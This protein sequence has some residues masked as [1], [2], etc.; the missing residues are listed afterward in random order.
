MSRI[1]KVLIVEDSKSDAKLIARELRRTGFSPRWERVET[2]PALREALLR[3]R[4]QLVISESTLPK[5]SLLEALAITKEIRSTTPFIVVS[6][7]INEET[8]GAAIR[9]G[10]AGYVTK[11]KLPGLGPALARELL[12]G[13]LRETRRDEPVPEPAVREAP[14]LQLVRDP[15]VELSPTVLDRM[16]LPSAIRWLVDR[17]SAWSTVAARVQLAPVGRLPAAV[18]AA[19]FRIAQEALANAERH[20]SARTLRVRLTARLGTIEIVVSDDG[21]G[22]DVAAAREKAAAGGSLGLLVMQEMVSLAGGELDIVSAP[23]RGTTVRARFPAPEVA[24]P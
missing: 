24:A 13:P 4:W 14:R 22:F 7:T 18:E 12:E 15:S 2:A 16:S 10:A 20:A 17:R 5:L 9:L 3:E 8:A 1:L 23:G 19:C 6:A 11:D 21:K